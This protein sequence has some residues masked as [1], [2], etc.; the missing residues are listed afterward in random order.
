MTII[1][2]IETGININ[3]NAEMIDMTELEVDQ[4]KNLAHMVINIVVDL[5]QNLKN[6]TKCC[7]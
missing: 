4:K 6:C 5:I 2:V 1:I 3:T 7:H